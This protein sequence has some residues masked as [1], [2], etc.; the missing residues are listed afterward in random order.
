MTYCLFQYLHFKLKDTKGNITPKF[1]S[2][3]KILNIE[4]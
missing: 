2:C 1:L 3:P 4:I